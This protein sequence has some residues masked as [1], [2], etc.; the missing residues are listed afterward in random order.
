MEPAS[1]YRKADNKHIWKL[2]QKV[3][4]KMAIRTCEIDLKNILHRPLNV[5]VKDTAQL[6]D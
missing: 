3:P 6:Y 5:D 2:N 4:E 1:V